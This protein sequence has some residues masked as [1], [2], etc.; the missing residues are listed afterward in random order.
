MQEDKP[1]VDGE[2]DMD[3]ESFEAAM[4]AAVKQKELKIQKVSSGTSPSSSS[5]H[6]PKPGTNTPAGDGD[7]VETTGDKASS[8]HS[9]DDD[10]SVS[11]DSSNNDKPKPS[12]EDCLERCDSDDHETLVSSSRRTMNMT[13]KHPF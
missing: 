3:A 5:H 7:I 12:L 1:D 4:Q 10:E 13:F 8:D 11:D 6:T 2:E 9:D